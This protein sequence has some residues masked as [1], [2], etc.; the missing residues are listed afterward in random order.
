MKNSVA[1]PFV[2]RAL[3]GANMRGADCSSVDQMNNGLFLRGTDDN[4]NAGAA[5]PAITVPTKFIHINVDNSSGGDLPGLV[6]FDSL[7][8]HRAKNNI[9]NPQN[10]T[11]SLASAPGNTALYEAYT[12]SLITTFQKV[13]AMKIKASGDNANVQINNRIN[14]LVYNQDGSVALD[15]YADPFE[16]EQE[17]RCDGEMIFKLPTELLL[18]GRVAIVIPLLAG[19]RLSIG[20]QIE[21]TVN[22]L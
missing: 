12:A 22:D 19:V 7:G 15:T 17:D 21:A 18:T 5:I 20:M 13:F 11:T 2:N 16:G 4:T 1:V 10:V 9:T 8:F 6:L 3:S 14:I